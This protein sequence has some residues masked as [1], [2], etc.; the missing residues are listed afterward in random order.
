MDLWLPAARAWP[1]WHLPDGPRLALLRVREGRVEP[2]EQ[3]IRR[4]LVDGARVD[5]VLGCWCRRS[6]R[7]VARPVIRTEYGVLGCRL[8]IAFKEGP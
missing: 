7:P 2:V 1:V 3:R 8:H 4:Y 5:R 6:A